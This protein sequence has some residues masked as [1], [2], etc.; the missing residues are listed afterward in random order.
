MGTP[1]SLSLSLGVCVQT[2]NCFLMKVWWYSRSMEVY[3]VTTRSWTTHSSQMAHPRGFFGIG[4]IHGTPD[5][6][7][8]LMTPWR[9]CAPDLAE[10]SG[11]L[12]LA[13]S[14][15]VVTREDAMADFMTQKGAMAAT[16]MAGDPSWQRR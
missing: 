10:A 8:E 7:V 1:L 3:D 9:A 5:Q 15:G 2:H 16:C 4:L 13:D 12:A 14:G 6:E 11:A